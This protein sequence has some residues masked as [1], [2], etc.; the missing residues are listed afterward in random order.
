MKLTEQLAFPCV[1]ATMEPPER[2][3]VVYY[4]ISLSRVVLNIIQIQNNVL[5]NWQYYAE[6]SIIQSECEK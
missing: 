5:H 3:H 4:M 1:R 6:Y 2:L